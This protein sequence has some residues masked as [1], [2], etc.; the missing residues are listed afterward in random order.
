VKAILAVNNRA[1]GACE[2]MQLYTH[3]VS[4]GNIPI[5][6]HPSSTA[7]NPMDTAK[8]YIAASGANLLYQWQHNT[9]SGYVDLSNGGYYAGVDDDTLLIINPPYSLNGSQYRCVVKSAGM[10]PTASAPALLHTSE[11][12]VGDLQDGVSDIHVFPNPA[13]GQA[14]IAAP[15]F[16]GRER[17][18]LY[19]VTGRLMQEGQISGAISRLDLTTY[20]TGTYYL[21]FTGSG[22]KMIRLIKN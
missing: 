18:S 10:C 1:L 8:F 6:Q 13:S 12:S 20:A 16:T 21:K 5:T 17:Y 19:D 22:K 14:T 7:I 2:I 11:T 4:P 15:S 3:V 9:G